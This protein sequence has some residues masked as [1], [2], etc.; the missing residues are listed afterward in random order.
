MCRDASTEETTDARSE[1]EHAEDEDHVIEVQWM[2]DKCIACFLALQH[3]STL[4]DV[5]QRICEATGVPVHEQRIFFEDK[6]LASEGAIFGFATI[7]TCLF[8]ERS[9]GDPF[10]TNMG[11]FHGFAKKPE[12]LPHGAF[13]VLRRIAPAI[14]G[15]VLEC[16][17]IGVEERTGC[18]GRVAVKKMS[19]TTVDSFKGHNTRER[20][21]HLSQKPPFHS[22]DALA[23]IG[24]LS[25]LSERPDLPQYLLKMHGIF[26]D[27]KHVWIVTELARGGDLFSLAASGA[28]LQEN[29]VKHYGHQLLLA[30]AYLHEHG[31]GHRDISLEN[32]LLDRPHETSCAANVRL[33]DFGMAVQS[34]SA[35]GTLLRYFTTVGKDFYRA[36][37]CYMPSMAREVS[38]LTPVKAQ[39]GEVIQTACNGVMCEVRLP[40]TAIPNKTCRAELWGYEAPSADVFSCAVCVFILTWQSPLWHRAVLTDQSFAFFRGNGDNGIAAL[41]RSWRKQAR[42]S[43]MLELVSEMLRVSPGRRPTASDCITRPWFAETRNLIAPYSIEMKQGPDSEQIAAV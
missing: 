29:H 26:A 38:V 11:Y 12:Q 1:V 27:T 20:S 33:M 18:E 22:E 2:A 42:S 31:I 36:P 10:D 17:R 23:E 5:K 32:V 6:Q 13:T 25:F 34:R 14:H 9:V 4:E 41:L 37:E 35:S 30:T 21:L 3:D 40:Q 43:D 28:E 16:Q 39:P 24:V 19:R 8:L 15:E 7:R